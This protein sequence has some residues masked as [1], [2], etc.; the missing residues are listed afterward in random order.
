MKDR[1]PLLLLGIIVALL[2]GMCLLAHEKGAVMVTTPG[3]E[4]QLKS[5]LGRGVVLRSA[6]QPV[7]VPA[8]AY[9]PIYLTLTGERDGETW[10]ASS[11]GPWGKLDRVQ[12]ARGRATDI[13]LG[14]PLLIKPEVTVYPG[15]VRVALRL[16]GCAGEQ[17]SNAILRNNQRIPGPPVKIIDEAGT[18]LASGQFQFG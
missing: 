12:I 2:A 8:R 6:S 9:R 3:V 4:L 10:K 18:V 15:Q 1:V 14:A 5:R 11:W 7:A 16:L 13:E 17:Y